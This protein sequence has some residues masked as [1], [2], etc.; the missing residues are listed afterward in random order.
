MRKPLKKLRC[1]AAGSEG[2][3]VYWSY[4]RMAERPGV[5]RESAV[6]LSATGGSDLRSTPQMVFFSG[7]LGA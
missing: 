4:M 7:L 5:Y 1:E 6:P 3:G 2:A